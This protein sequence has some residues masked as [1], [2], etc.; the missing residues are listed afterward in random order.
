MAR[1]TAIRHINY[2]THARPLST[3]S[4]P[5]TGK[6]RPSKKQGKRK[7]ANKTVRH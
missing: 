6:W 3:S 1:N 5:P 2:A 4:F 7:P